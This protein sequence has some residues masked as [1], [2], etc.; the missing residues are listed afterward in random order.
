MD[1][2]NSTNDEQYGDEQELAG[3]VFDMDELNIE[4]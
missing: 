3:E 4:L 2:R 1:Y